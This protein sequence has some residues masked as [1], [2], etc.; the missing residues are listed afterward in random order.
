MLPIT[1]SLLLFL[2]LLF[3]FLFTTSETSAVCP[4]DAALSFSVPSISGGDRMCVQCRCKH[5][6]IQIMGYWQC[7]SNYPGI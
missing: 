2:L 7:T 3:F 5:S 1:P 6:L 4:Y